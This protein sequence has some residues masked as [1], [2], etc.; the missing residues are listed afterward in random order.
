MCTDNL[1]VPLVAITKKKYFIDLTLLEFVR[2]L[3]FSRSVSVMTMNAL[4]AE[5]FRDTVRTLKA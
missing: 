2:G 5:S 4:L 1:N 3:L